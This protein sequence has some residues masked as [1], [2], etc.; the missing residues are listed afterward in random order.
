MFTILALV[1]TSQRSEYDWA[2]YTTPHEFSHLGTT[3][4]K[5]YWPRG[6]VLVGTSMMN[7]LQ[8]TRGSK[9]DFD[10]WESNGCTGWGYK[11]VLPYFL[12]SED[13]H[14]EDLR[15]SVYHSIGGTMAVTGGRATPL[16]DL[17]IKAGPEL[18]Y[19]KTDYNGEKQHGFAK[20]QLNIKD[21]I[22]SS[23]AIKLLSRRK[24]N[25]H[26]ATR[27]F[28]CKIEIK[29]K[30]ATGVFIIK[31]N[32][33]RFVKARKEVILS[34]GAII[35]PQILMLSG[36]GPKDHLQA[37]RIEP[38]KDLAVGQNLQDHMVVLM[39]STLDKTISITADVVGNI[40]TRLRYFFFGKG[41]LGFVATDGNAFLHTEKS[42]IDKTGAD[43]QLEFLSMLIPYNAMRME[44]RKS[45]L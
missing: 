45:I 37:L 6:R 27:A 11:D 29:N 36:I 40:W 38:V 19:E 33:K 17:Y 44:L 42:Q 26:I 12:K 28:V 39:Y 2:Y 43:I 35:T 16:A 15:S 32:K 23:P 10:E 3:D 30:R 8:Y 14:I 31:D 7:F 13:I 25:L 4:R 22:R 41:P 18:G 9:Y 1:F 21:G 34:A 20:V 5:G 24:E